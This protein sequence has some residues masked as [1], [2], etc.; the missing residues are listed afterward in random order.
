MDRLE[1][2]HDNLRAALT[3]SLGPG[4]DTETGLRLTGALSHFWYMREHHSE[5]RTWLES[6][7]ERS[8]DATARAK[9]SSA[10]CGWPG[11]RASSR[12]PTRWQR[13][14]LLYTVR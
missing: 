12:G 11:S 8:G 5:S 3:W 4:G 2:E 14:A 13:R 1:T 9:Y 10:P 6:A 7:L